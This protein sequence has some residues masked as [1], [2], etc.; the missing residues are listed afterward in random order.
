MLLWQKK[1][2]INSLLGGKMLVPVTAARMFFIILEKYRTGVA[3]HHS[4][5]CLPVGAQQKAT[6]PE[7]AEYFTYE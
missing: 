4:C 2:F 6:E 7:E 5:Q 3:V 1:M